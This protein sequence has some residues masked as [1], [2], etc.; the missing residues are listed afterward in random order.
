[1]SIDERILAEICNKTEDSANQELSQHSLNFI[2]DENRQVITYPDESFVTL[3]MNPRL[4][5]AEF[6]KVTGYL[7]DK[8][9]AVNEYKDPQ[10]GWVFYNVYDKDYMLKDLVN[11]QKIFLIVGASAVIFVT[12][13]I[14]YT[15]YMLN[16]SVRSVLKGIGQVQQGHLDVVIPEDTEDEIGIIARNF[17]TMTVKVK[18]L[19]TTVKE[20]QNSQKMQKSVH[21]RHRST[22]ISYITPWIPLTGWRLKRE[23]MKSVRC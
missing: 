18:E 4:S 22:L 13:I 12:C 23:S 15:V 19:V 10:T 6:V 3:K 17:N 1:M 20:A 2:L 11:T 7:R 16:R 21:W 8:N 9:T 5:V 14:S